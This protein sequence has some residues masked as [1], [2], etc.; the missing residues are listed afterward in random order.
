MRLNHNIS[1]LSIYNGYKKNL[2]NNKSVIERLSTGIKINSAKDN[3]NKIGQSE[4]M[5]IQIKSLQAVQRNL[6]DG[7]SMLQTA[8]GALQ[9]VNNTLARI[10]ELSVSAANGTKSESEK[11]IIQ[12]EIEEMK[13]NIDDLA[14]N[15]E[16]NGVKLLCDERV[17]NNKY[18]M[19]KNIVVGGMQG[20]Q[21]RIPSFNIRTEILKDEKG[22]TLKDIDIRT[23]KGVNSALEVIDESIETVSNI[24]SRYGAMQ[25]RLETTAENI[26]SNEQ[27]FERAVSN[28]IDSDIAL[29]MAEL[30]RTQILNDSSLALISQSNN[31]PK[32]ALRILERVR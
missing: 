23:Q 8:D 32:D 13:K 29:E 17:P 28:L 7:V 24:R 11:E 5:R 22:N 26:G 6:Q 16:F 14:N 12:N 18:P 21:S 2:I 10:K 19:Y 25:N 30:A 20:E 3:P 31:L 4:Q 15:T 1:S 9:E 27:A